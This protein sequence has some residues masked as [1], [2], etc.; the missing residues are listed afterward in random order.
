MPSVSSSGAQRVSLSSAA[1]RSPVVAWF[2]AVATVLWLLTVLW[3]NDMGNMPGT[4]GMSIPSFVVMWTLMMAAMMLPSTS[5]L[6][7]LYA[8]GIK[9]DRAFRLTT[10][11]VGYLV[12]WALS[13]LAA[14]GFAWIGGELAQQSVGAAQTAAV[15]VFVLVGVYQ[16]TP[17]KLRCLHHCRSPLG[18]IMHFASYRGPSRDL[19]AGAVH[20]WFCLGCC[21]AL[22]LLMIAFGVM[23][24]WAMV[25]LTVVIAAEK[26]SS[27]GVLIA[28]ASG[29]GSL[30]LAG[31]VVWVPGI[32]PGLDPDRVM[33]GMTG[34]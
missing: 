28:K 32:A 29:V 23:N 1:L 26:L 2:C 22:M 11:A 16:L 24:L 14:Y 6:A 12:A 9:T 17:L 15:S 27:H 10:F 5:P 7:A 19:R 21:W 33:S 34:M 8:R 18:H 31:V 25:G 13:G 30:L 3:A 4:M 20:G